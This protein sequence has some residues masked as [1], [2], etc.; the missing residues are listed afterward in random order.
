MEAENPKPSRLQIPDLPA[1]PEEEAPT[2]SLEGEVDDLYS[3]EEEEESMEEE[4]LEEE[5]EVPALPPAAPR[6]KAQKSGRRWDRPTGAAEPDEEDESDGSGK[7]PAQKRLNFEQTPE[8]AP[9]KISTVIGS[10]HLRYKSWRRWKHPILECLRDSGGN[11]AFVR[12]YML[13]KHG[14]S[15]P[16]GVIRYYNSCRR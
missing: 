1:A 3:S 16:P 14:V 10:Q 9:Q 4:S 13:F 6:K 12:R 5:V 15:V 7:Q 11:T 8:A 2:S